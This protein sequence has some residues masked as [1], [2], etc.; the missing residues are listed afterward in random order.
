MRVCADDLYA[1]APAPS[2]LFIAL[3][4]FS[5]DRFVIGFDS[6]GV[7]WREQRHRNFEKLTI[8]EIFQYKTLN[9][10]L[11]EL[12]KRSNAENYVAVMSRTD[13]DAVENRERKGKEVDEEERKPDE[14]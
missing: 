5:L 13:E 7:R 14:D 2:L 4:F 9:Y 8:N 6:G 11:V 3:C 10:K 12:L 1:S